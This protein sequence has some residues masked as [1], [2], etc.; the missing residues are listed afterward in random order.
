MNGAKVEVKKCDPHS[1]NPPLNV[2]LVVDEDGLGLVEDYLKRVSVFGLDLETN[3][4]D[5]FYDRRIRTI[6][7]GDREEQYVIDL[8]AFAGSTEDLIYGQGSF[9]GELKD[10]LGL[11]RVADALRPSF[12]SD[13]WLKVGHNL[14]FEYNTLTWC[15][16]VSPW[17]LYCTLLAEK[18]IHCGAVNFFERGFWGL[19]DLVRRYCRLEISKDEQKTFDLEKPLTE[20]QVIYGALDCRLPISIKN[21]Q[22]PLLT[23]GDL[24]RACKIDFDALPAFGD[25][26]LNGMLMDQEKWM[27]LVREVQAKQKRIVASMDEHFIPVVGRKGIP[28]YDLDALEAAWRETPMKMREE[29]AEARKRYMA[30]RKAI[31]DARKALGTYEGEASLNYRSS[32]QLRSALLD[33]SGFSSRNLPNTDDKTLDK[34]AGRPVID[35]I[36]E[37][38]ATNKILT[39]YG[40]G[41]IEKYT[42][43]STGRIH[44][45]INVFGAET[46]R[47]SSSNPN[48]QNILHG[49]DWRGCFVSRPGWSIITADYSG[50]ELRIMTEY[51]RQKS[52]IEAFD[53]G[54]DVHCV[55]AE[56]IFKDKWK[57][58]ACD[59][60]EEYVKDGV[61]KKREPCAYYYGGKQKCSCPIHRDLRDRVK[62]LNFGLAYGLSARRLSN[63]LKIPFEEA[64]AMFDE[65]ERTNEELLQWLGKAAKKASMTGESRTLS[66][67]RRQFPKPTWTDATRI[68]QNKKKGELPSTREITKQYKAMFA[69]IEREGKNTPIQGTGADMVK[70]AMGCGKDRQGNLFLWHKL[71]EIGAKFYNC[72][73]DEIV[74]EVPD[75]KVEECFKIVGDSM[76]RAG[77]EFVNVV[78]MD[79]EGH[80]EKKWKK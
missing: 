51:S 62:A 54:W 37:F 42:H 41:F 57:E 4:T 64:Q 1:M 45:N 23:K 59:G 43:K 52:W 32:D 74:V 9:G 60:T 50:Q 46:G 24:F 8:L 20:N 11:K 28:D 40:S 33:M 19:E 65:Y 15:L 3:I 31:N 13:K 17:N 72:V 66:N 47:T 30:A 68:A 79:F 10:F 2:K 44:S 63:E 80:I 77:A 70:L 6:Q 61:V 67:R 16:G 27:G 48:V 55:V 18:N 34:L 21:A 78:K 75:E 56:L 73:H 53:N 14:E 36:R 7:I 5:S 25:M 58:G 76:L 69:G 39:T 71:R 29:R 38:R 26:H 12:E 49:A 22:H 35:L